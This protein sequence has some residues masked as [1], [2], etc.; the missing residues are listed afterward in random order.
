MEGPGLPAQWKPHAVAIP[1][2]DGMDSLNAAVAVGIALYE[3]RRA[4][5][6]WPVG[7]NRQ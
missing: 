3:W 1:M 6:H 2:A 7:D 5:A 4:Q